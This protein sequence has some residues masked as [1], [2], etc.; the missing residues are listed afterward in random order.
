MRK[1]LKNIFL[2][3]LILVLLFSLTG[4][5]DNENDSEKTTWSSNKYA[6][7]V[8]KPEAGTIYEESELDSVYDNV[9]YVGYNIDLKDWTIEEC[10]AYAEK[11][12]DAGFNSPGENKTT[13]VLIDTESTYSF[14]AKNSDGIYATASSNR[15][16]GRVSIREIK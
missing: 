10:K 3:S 8:P 15:N 6:N 7:L 11:L 16:S 13:I 4:C 5:G 14:G 12:K 1:S 9:H 2:T